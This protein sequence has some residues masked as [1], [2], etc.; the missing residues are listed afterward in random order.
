MG[1]TALLLEKIQCAEQQLFLAKLGLPTVQNVRA[2]G[3]KVGDLG[4]AV[5]QISSLQVKRTAGW[6]CRKAGSFRFQH[7]GNHQVQ[8]TAGWAV[9]TVWKYL[10]R[11]EEVYTT[12]IESRYRQTH[13]EIE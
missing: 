3:G 5:G 11:E 13:E 9:G 1:D 2:D 4:S 7:W 10:F 8:R 6:N 12:P